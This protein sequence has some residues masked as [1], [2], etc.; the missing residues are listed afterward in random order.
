METMVNFQ[1]HNPAKIVFGPGSEKEI[2]RLLQEEKVTSLLM[3]YSGEFIKE[4]GIF[5][6]VKEACENLNID[7]YENDPRWKYRLRQ[8]PLVKEIPGI[9]LI[10]NRQRHRFGGINRT[11]TAHSQNEVHLFLLAKCCQ[12]PN[13]FNGRI[14]NKK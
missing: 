4:L 2:H 13:Q 5:D 6:T 9:S 3:I 11:S 8:N 10:R 12:I 7:F 14:R 1:Y